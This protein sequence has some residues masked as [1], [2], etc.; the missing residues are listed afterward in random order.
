MAHLKL[1]HARIGGEL[2]EINVGFFLQH[3][4]LALALTT[5]IVSKT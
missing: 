4:V 1:M 5:I 2:L 3:Q